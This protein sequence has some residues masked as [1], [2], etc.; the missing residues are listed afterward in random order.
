MCRYGLLESDSS[1]RSFGSIEPASRF[2][3]GPVALYR[4][5]RLRR[6]T[7]HKRAVSNAAFRLGEAANLRFERAG[8]VRPLRHDKAFS[9]TTGRLMA[10]SIA[11]GAGYLLDASFAL[12]APSLSESLGSSVVVLQL[13]EPVMILWLLVAGARMRR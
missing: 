6:H 5:G 8:G 1:S 4:H 3:S 2:G 10:S 11:G 9:S 13:G 12:L 7:A